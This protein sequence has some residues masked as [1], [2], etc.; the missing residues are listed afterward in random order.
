MSAFPPLTIFDLE[1]T[2]LDPRKGHR[3]IEIAGVR[4]EGGKIAEGATFA[5]FVNPERDIPWEARQI[6]RISDEDVQA[7][8]T[9][10]AVLPR[11]LD[12]AKGSIL[13]AH[14]AAFDMGF[15]EVEKGYCWGF[16][17]LPE[18]LCTMRLSQSLYP[19]EF[20]HNLDVLA[21]KFNL[22]VPRERHRALADSFLAAQALQRMLT[23]GQIDSIEKLRKLA[24]IKQLVA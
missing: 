8:D 21:R 7:A 12:F 15:M 11:F 1:T 22:T 23:E 2:G 6:N 20:R 3:I 13:V 24:S 9:I 19:R 14:N 5:A 4:F 17:D 18:C 16:V 10:D